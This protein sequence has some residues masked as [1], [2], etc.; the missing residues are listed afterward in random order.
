MSDKIGRIA[1]IIGAVIDVSFD[2]DESEGKVFLPAIYEALKVV[3]PDGR[4]LVLEVQ[5]HIGDDT[6][7][8]V[9]MDRTAG[10]SRGMKVVA[11][12]LP[13]TMPVG[14]QIKGRMMNVIG[15]SIDG[16]GKLDR[17]GAYPIHREAPKFE[18]LSTV[19]EVL[20]TGI[21]VIDLLEP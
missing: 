11:T 7:R 8:A 14:C 12:G 13:I 10:L 3:M 5:Q 20:Y 9:A 21:K 2:A 4:E 19:Q 18:D 6:V 17:A 1:Q 15:S 16:L